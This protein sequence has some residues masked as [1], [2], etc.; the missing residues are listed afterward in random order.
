MINEMIG[1]EIPVSPLASTAGE[2]SSEPPDRDVEGT[3]ATSLSPVDGVDVIGAICRLLFV[4]HEPI[5][6]R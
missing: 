6:E 2:P 1:G 3:L 5:S 4:A